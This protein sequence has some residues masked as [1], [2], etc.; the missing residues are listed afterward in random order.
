MAA[1]WP[2]SNVSQPP[3]N[4]W[5]ESKTYL[6]LRAGFDPASGISTPSL[7]ER[8]NMLTLNPLGYSK[9]RLSRDF[10]V[11]HCNLTE[12]VER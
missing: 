9:L 3:E 7:P 11:S 10:G 4:E 2:A 1:A 5:A 6:T 12:L 8:S